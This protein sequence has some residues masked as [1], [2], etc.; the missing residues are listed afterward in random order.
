MDIRNAQKKDYTS[1]HELVKIAF[2]TAEMPPAN[3][4]D[5]VLKWRASDNYISEL[6][7][8]AKEKDDIIGHIMLQ[9]LK[10]HTINGKCISF[11]NSRKV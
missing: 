4:E 10:V 1:I 11:L 9:K 7:F 6:E 2:Q 3:E 8:V 5:Y